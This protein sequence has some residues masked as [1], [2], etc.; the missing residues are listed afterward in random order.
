MGKAAGN[1]TMA[2]NELE[3]GTLPVLWLQMGGRIA[4]LHATDDWL[5]MWHRPRRMTYRQ[6]DTKK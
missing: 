5:R 6:Y 2:A 3:N 4:S 1:P